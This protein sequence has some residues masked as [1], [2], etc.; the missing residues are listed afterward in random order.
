MGQDS[1]VVHFD[2]ASDVLSINVNKVD[3]VRAPL[4]PIVQKLIDEFGT[5]PGHESIPPDR[6]VIEERSP[7]I[8]V[9]FY[10]SRVSGRRTDKGL[11]VTQIQT[12]VLIHQN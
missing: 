12:D 3:E 7:I 2:A 10:I 9:G 1:V 11:N 8:N 5:N 4:R 6:L